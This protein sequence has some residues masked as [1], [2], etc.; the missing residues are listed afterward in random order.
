MLVSNTL[1]PTKL[2]SM[3]NH[4]YPSIKNLDFYINNYDRCVVLGN[5]VS[6]NDYVKEEKDFTIGVNDIVRKFN[7]NI[8]LLVDTRQQFWRKGGDERV[9]VIE[10]SDCIHFVRDD[11]WDFKAGSTYMFKLGSK[12]TYNNFN[13][14]DTIDVGWDSPYMAIMLAAK[15]GFRKIDVIGVDYT[16]NHFYATDGPHNL[17]PHSNEVNAMYKNLDDFLSKKGITVRNI[18]KVSNLKGLKFA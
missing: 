13:S 12:G 5:G 1:R 10:N 6:V 14:P 9:S 3:A 18:S 7:P 17:A 16:N 2:S 15:L 8:L 4:N 11:A